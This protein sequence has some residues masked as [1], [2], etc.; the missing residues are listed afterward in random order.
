MFYTWMQVKKNKKEKAKVNHGSHVTKAV[1]YLFNETCL[2]GYDRGIIGCFS[3]FGLKK[4]DRH[5]K[6]GEKT[7]TL[8]PYLQVRLTASQHVKQNHKPPT[9]QDNTGQ[10]LKMEFQLPLGNSKQKM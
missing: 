8:L 10:R 2:F 4:Y 6:S 9:K 7:C 5:L 1:E 3:C